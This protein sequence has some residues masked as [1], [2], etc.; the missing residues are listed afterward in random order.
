MRAA[1]SAARLVQQLESVRGGA[2]GWGC[3]ERRALSAD[4]AVSR[5]VAACVVERL[6]IVLPT[7][8]SWE[9]EYQA[10]DGDACLLFLAVPPRR[11]LTLTG[12]CSQE[13]RYKKRLP[14]FKTLPAVSYA[15]RSVAQ[16]P[17]LTPWL[18]NRS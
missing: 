1:R 11:L 8:P 17:C 7:E 3:E 14:D 6:P 2:R 9:A 12:L 15:H 16:A 18:C 4:A 10:R 5:V 13:W